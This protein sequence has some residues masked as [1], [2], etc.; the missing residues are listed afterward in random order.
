MRA[1][2]QSDAAGGVAGGSGGGSRV[3]VEAGGCGGPFDYFL[4]MLRRRWL[5]DHRG[6]LRVRRASCADPDGFTFVEQLN[7]LG[8]ESPTPVS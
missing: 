2:R 3:E 1:S 7:P 5:G 8:S 4:E 6:E